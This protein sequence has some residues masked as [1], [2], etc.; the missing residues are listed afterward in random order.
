M[1][2]IFSCDSFLKVEGS[3][4]MMGKRLCWWVRAPPVPPFQ[5]T[6]EGPVARGCRSPPPSCACVRS[7]TFQAPLAPSGSSLAPRPAPQT[8]LA[9]PHRVVAST[10]R[11]VLAELLPGYLV[12]SAGVHTGGSWHHGSRVGSPQGCLSHAGPQCPHLRH[13]DRDGPAPPPVC[14][15]FGE[16]ADRAAVLI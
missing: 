11:S 4:G 6:G 3:H 7:P 8:L 14:E 2:K 13:G 9:P 12:I 15:G 1:A 5:A 10:R 16:G